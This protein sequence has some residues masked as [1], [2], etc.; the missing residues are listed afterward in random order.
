MGETNC[1][2]HSKPLLMSDTS[3]NANEVKTQLYFNSKGA[4]S[5]TDE[6]ISDFKAYNITVS[7]YKKLI[8]NSQLFRS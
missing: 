6:E 4:K 8:Y 5:L 7:L 1:A 2:A 3:V